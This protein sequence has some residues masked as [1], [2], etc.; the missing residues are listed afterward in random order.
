M[1]NNRVV[2]IFSYKC[3]RIQKV[4][5]CVKKREM[6]SSASIIRTFQFRALVSSDM[7][8]SLS[9]FVFTSLRYS[10]KYLCVC[11]CVWVWVRLCPAVKAI[12]PHNTRGPD[13]SVIYCPP[14]P[15]SYKGCET[16]FIR[17]RPLQA[18]RGNH[19]T[20]VMSFLFLSTPFP[21]PSSCTRLRVG[22][23]RCWG[24]GRV[25]RKRQS[26]STKMETHKDA[27]AVYLVSLG[28]QLQAAL[29]KT[30]WTHRQTFFDLKNVDPGMLNSLLQP[31]SLFF[32][33][34]ISL[35]G[36]CIF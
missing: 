13:V 19:C 32:H 22:C 31:L 12:R 3:D 17:T 35:V 29:R 11:V 36:C 7:L 14:P 23:C 18:L 6:D 15:I 16:S 1:C 9:L 24:T 27:V 28:R 21:F 5:V 4:C 33:W 25:T 2:P 34:G 10:D 30:H 8:I 26:D 20:F